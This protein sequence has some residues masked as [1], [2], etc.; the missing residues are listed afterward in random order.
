M[1][2]EGGG[3]QISPENSIMLSS[4]NLATK[5]I[6]RYIYIHVYIYTEKNICT[7]NGLDQNSHRN[8]SKLPKHTSGRVASHPRQNPTV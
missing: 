5:Y 2:T 6:D 1:Q 7:K 3:C 4:D 8:P